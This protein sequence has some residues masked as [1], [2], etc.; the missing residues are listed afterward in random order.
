MTLKVA[1]ANLWLPRLMVDAGLAA[2]TSE[3]R[4]LIKRAGSRLTGKRSRI[5]NWNWLRVRLTS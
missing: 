3:A 4:R 1:E 5:P 2:S